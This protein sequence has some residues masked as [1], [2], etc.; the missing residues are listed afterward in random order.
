MGALDKAILD[1]FLRRKCE[2]TICV[3]IVF[4]CQNGIRSATRDANSY[5]E[6]E[7]GH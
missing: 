6:E 2:L 5:Y 1:K 7:L 4:F 3:G